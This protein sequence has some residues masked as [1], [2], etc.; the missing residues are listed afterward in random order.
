MTQDPRRDITTRCCIVGGGPAGMMLGLLLARAGV[1]VTVL[2]KH[3]DFLRD[4]RGDTVHPSTLE[5]LRDL[6]LLERFLAL[7][8]R[9]EEQLLAQFADGMVAFADFR[10]LKP[11]AYLALAPQWD[12]LDLLAAE[13]R[14]Y[15]HYDLR[16]RAE[17]KSLIR[18]GGRITGVEAVTP[19]GPLTMRADLVVGTD[20]RHSTLRTAAG[21]APVE[22]GAPMDV[23]WFRLTRLATDIDHTF[24]IAGRGK[25]MALINRNDYWQA[26]LIIPKGSG[27]ARRARP[28]AEFQAEIAG[29]APFLA[30]RTGEIQSWKDVSLLSVSVDRLQ[31]WHL[32]GLLLIG[33]AAHAMSPVGGV[34]IN[35]AIQDA[36][37]AANI[38]GPVLRDGGIPDERLLARV[39]GRRMLPTRLVQGIQR[40]MQRN[41]IERVLASAGPPP[42]APALMRFLFGF[43]F[44][45]RIP[46]RVFGLGFRRERLRLPAAP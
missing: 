7:P 9:R 14:R 45:R 15:P 13:S 27:A 36:V 25:M 10:G 8:H 11:F 37:A 26:G 23:L 30:A 4:F 33:D 28:I 6:N 39:Q 21:F 43:R 1:P 34:G 18:E 46:A 16:M 32:P 40:A 44:V 2:E 12:F 17:A 24:G 38:V 5:L 20:G 22:F 35:L 42:K 41:V 19:D 3:G 31:R 29:L